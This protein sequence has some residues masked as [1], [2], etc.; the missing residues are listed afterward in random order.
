LEPFELTAKGLP[1]RKI[2]TIDHSRLTDDYVW[3]VSRPPDAGPETGFEVGRLY[4][5]GRYEPLSH[6]ASY[7]LGVINSVSD[8]NVEGEPVAWIAGDYGLMRVSLSRPAFSRRRF[9]L[10]PSRIMTADGTPISIRDAK[11]L[12]L[13]YDG[14]DFQIHFGTDRF[15]VGSQ[16]YYEARLEGKVEHQ[17]PVTTAAVWRSGALNEGHYLLHL[18][19]TDDN[20]VQSKE[21]TLAFTINPP[22]YRTLWMVSFRD[23]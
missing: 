15:S 2:N 11:G 16:L 3:V 1:G 18:R 20:G 19:A 13:S 6:A 9:E 17:F 7:S 8:E 22:W 14:R 10:Y 12:T 4:H 5:T 21:Y 23:Y